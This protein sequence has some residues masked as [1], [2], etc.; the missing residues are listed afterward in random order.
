VTDVTDVLV[1]LL[2]ANKRS[3]MADIARMLAKVKT[4]IATK[5]I[6]LQRCLLAVH[7]IPTPPFTFTID[8]KQ[9]FIKFKECV[10]NRFETLDEEK[11]ALLLLWDAVTCLRRLP[12]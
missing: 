7:T 1:L 3:D 12:M 11:G 2:D 9:F 10:Y 8:C 6:E 4:F 5:A